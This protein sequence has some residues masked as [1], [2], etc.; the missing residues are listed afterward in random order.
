MGSKMPAPKATAAGSKMPAPKATTMMPT[1]KCMPQRRFGQGSQAL[2]DEADV[3]ETPLGGHPACTQ[4][5]DCLGSPSAALVQHL[6]EDEV[7][8]D[9]YC[10]TCWDALTSADP[11]LQAV[12][13]AEE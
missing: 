6:E 7:P 13:V 5:E 9:I 10:T 4:A 11:N 1:A 2:Y 3:A 12:D 8:A